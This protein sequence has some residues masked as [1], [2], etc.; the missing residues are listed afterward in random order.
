MNYREFLFKK[1]ILIKKTLGRL[2]IYGKAQLILN[3]I[4]KSSGKFLR[5]RAKR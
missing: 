3:E 1:P 2:M 5:V 4:K